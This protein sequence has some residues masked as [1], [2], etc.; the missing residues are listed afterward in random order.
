MVDRRFVECAAEIIRAGKFADSRGWTPATSGNFS[1]RLDQDRVA[2]T[3]SGAAKGFLTEK[4]ILVVDREGLA[5]EPGKRPSAETALHW[6]AY[7][8]DSATGAVVHIHSLAATVLTR[9]LAGESTLVLEGY[10]LSKAFA[11]T[12]SH[13]T[14]L[15]LPVLENDQDTRALAQRARAALKPAGAVPG[16]LI[17]GHGAYTWGRDMT[18]ALRHAEALE[19]LLAC[20]LEEKRITR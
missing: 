9:L 14:R 18:E 20:L 3:E 17:R 10:E 19:F 12:S 2:I 1:M 6:E 5:I 15:E 13:S 4:Q 8:R 11:G 7:D 16:Y